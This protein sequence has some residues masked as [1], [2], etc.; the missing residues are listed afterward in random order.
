MLKKTKSMSLIVG[1]LTVSISQGATT[2]C[3][4]QKYGLDVI[5]L[6][7]GEPAGGGYDTYGRL[8][9]RYIQRH[10]PGQ[11]TVVVQNMPGAGSLN[12]MN[13]VFNVAPRDGSTFATVQRGIIMMPLL[14]MSEANFHPEKLFYLGSLDQEVGVCVVR[15]DAGINSLEDVK[16]R[17]LIVGIE[18]SVSN[19][20]GLNLPLMKA[21]DLK[22]KV[23]S[24]YHGTGQ[25]NIAIERGELQGRCGVSYTSLKRSTTF[26]QDGRVKVLVQMGL[27]KHPDLPNVPLV[28]DFQMSDEDRG[29][30]ELLLAPT[31]I[32]RPFFLPPGVPTERAE[33][34]RAAFDATLAD[35]EFRAEAEKVGLPMRTMGGK[36]M[37]TLVEHI[38][39][40]PPKV[41]ER[42]KFLLTP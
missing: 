29:A 33:M 19:I 28:N 17:E 3:H 16:K 34:L 21:L 41:I 2:A 12:A 24:G 1:L 10:I 35:L 36:E 8:L 30:M 5:K 25:I 20:N 23:V 14:G 27:A 15:A 40:A 38:Y 13:H 11:P 22:L 6:I 32:S 9:A 42:A 31:A 7:V 18:G 39:R 26:L 37:Q 4:A